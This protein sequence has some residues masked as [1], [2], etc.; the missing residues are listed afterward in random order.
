MRPT[1]RALLTWADAV[2]ATHRLLAESH[3]TKA[4]LRE[5]W[6]GGP[7]RYPCRPDWGAAAAGRQVEG[8]RGGEAYEKS[9]EIRRFQVSPYPEEAELAPSCAAKV[10]R[11]G[12][13]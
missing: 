8:E 13:D 1:L 10:T 6:C 5:P 12:K 7:P 4:P 2:L 11:D 9:F 3:P